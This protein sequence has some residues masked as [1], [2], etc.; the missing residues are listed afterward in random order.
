VSVVA[1]IVKTVNV[2]VNVNAMNNKDI[3]K[4]NDLIAEAYQQVNEQPIFDPSD[5]F[6]DGIKNLRDPN[7][8]GGLNFKDP[9]TIPDIIDAMGGPE[10]VADIRDH[11]KLTDQVY[12]VVVNKLGTRLSSIN[13]EFLRSVASQV[14][15]H[16]SVE[17]AKKA[18]D[19]LP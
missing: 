10:V 6:A 14:A 1:T 9:N 8:P 15:S 5:K 11:E 7:T 4:E 18:F 12:D 17:Q 2:V 16:P 3:K 19:H 13:Q